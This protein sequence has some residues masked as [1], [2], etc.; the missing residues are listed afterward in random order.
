MTD[1]PRRSS[2]LTTHL[3]RRGCKDYTRITAHSFTDQSQT[4][5]EIF[6]TYGA[7]D[8]EEAPTMTLYYDFKPFN[9][10]EPVLLSLMIKGPGFKKTI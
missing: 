1:D 3:I 4:L 2:C 6:K 10:T 7:D 8:K 9:G 5:F